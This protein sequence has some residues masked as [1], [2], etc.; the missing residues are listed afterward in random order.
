MP[1]VI[2]AVLIAL[3]IGAGLGSLLPGL[4][5]PGRAENEGKAESTLGPPARLTM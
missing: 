3:V 5:V 4:L 2:A 1:R